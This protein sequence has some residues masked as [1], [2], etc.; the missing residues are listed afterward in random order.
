MRHTV[1]ARAEAQP[2]MRS[3]CYLEGEQSVDGV[4]AE[5][6]EL[7]SKTCAQQ[8]DCRCLAEVDNAVCWS[9]G[10]A[11]L[12]EQNNPVDL[13]APV[14]VKSPAIA[15]HFYLEEGLGVGLAIKR[16]CG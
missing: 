2:C 7:A 3:G 11:H 16:V 15:C 4:R 12:E 13:V 9:E 6:E 8:E 14:S 10:Y 5:L 1:S